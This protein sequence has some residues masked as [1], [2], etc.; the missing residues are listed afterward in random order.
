MV[1]IHLPFFDNYDERYLHDIEKHHHHQLV[2]I[3]DRNPYQERRDN[4]KRHYNSRFNEHNF[5][6]TLDCV[7]FVRQFRSLIPLRHTGLK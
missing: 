7:A 1:T 5:Q 4:K 3:L 2:V 6:K